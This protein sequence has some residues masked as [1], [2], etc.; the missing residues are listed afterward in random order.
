M[1]FSGVMTALVTPMAQGA[2]DEDALRALVRAQRS[3]AVARDEESR[4]GAVVGHHRV[5][6]AEIH[7]LAQQS[8]PGYSCNFL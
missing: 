8:Y 3:L 2:V 1:T 7:G 5:V 4:S 6:F